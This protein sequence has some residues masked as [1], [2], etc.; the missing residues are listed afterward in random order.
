MLGLAPTLPS[1]PLGSLLVLLHLQL[2][3]RN[4][5]TKRPCSTTGC[6]WMVV[7]ASKD[8]H[9]IFTVMVYVFLRQPVH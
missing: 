5:L 9:T 2:H 7:S 1:P 8:S 4:T 6:K 3:I